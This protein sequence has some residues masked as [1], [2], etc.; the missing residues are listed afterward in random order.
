MCGDLII[1]IR[2]NF[3]LITTHYS[4]FSN[5][6]KLQCGKWCPLYVMLSQ[7]EWINIS[8][9]LLQYIRNNYM[10]FLPLKW[11]FFS[12]Q[13][14][15]TF[16]CCKCFHLWEHFTLFQKLLMTVTLETFFHMTV[17][18]HIR[19]NFKLKN[20]FTLHKKKTKYSCHLISCKLTL[21]NTQTD[22]AMD[23]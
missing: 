8:T 18:I 17:L 7:M 22:R 20:L 6:C 4:P 12:E 21:T 16:S 10:Y 13:R 9:C 5:V 23:I 1:K 15:C 14:G 11:G 3:S 2:L 19:I